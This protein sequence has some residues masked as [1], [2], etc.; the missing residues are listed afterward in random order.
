MIVREINL[1]IVCSEPEGLG[2]GE[3]IR[4]VSQLALS[5]QGV[6]LSADDDFICTAI[7][8]LRRPFS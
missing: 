5:R 8:L 7:T 6:L 4:M 1:D 3:W 2:G